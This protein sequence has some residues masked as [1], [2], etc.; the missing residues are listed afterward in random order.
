[1]DNERLAHIR[2]I[3]AEELEVSVEKVRPNASFLGDLGADS[4]GLVELVMA[5]E[6]KF[7]FKVP[8]DDIEKLHTVQDAIDYVEAHAP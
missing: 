5:M 8:E 1:M 6:E 2:T 7:G 4:L 3:I